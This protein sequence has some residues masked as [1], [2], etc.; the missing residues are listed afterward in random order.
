MSRQ[1]TTKYLDYSEFTEFITSTAYVIWISDSRSPSST[2]CKPKTIKLVF[3]TSALSTQHS[4]ERANIGWLGI[5]I[6]CLSEA[7]C[8]PADCC[9][10]E[11]AL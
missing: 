8:L 9:F 10:I 1:P 11:L 3:V 6:M 4:E 7:T 2:V 5:R